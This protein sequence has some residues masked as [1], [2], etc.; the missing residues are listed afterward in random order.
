M[1]A[2]LGICALPFPISCHVSLALCTE[3]R[4]GVKGKAPPAANVRTPSTITMRRSSTAA[5]L[6]FSLGVDVGAGILAV[7]EKQRTPTNWDTQGHCIISAR[8][9]RGEAELCC[10]QI[11]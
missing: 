10:Y 8:V 7:H 1:L 5:C 3:C 6:T 4:L 11:C 9:R 2:T